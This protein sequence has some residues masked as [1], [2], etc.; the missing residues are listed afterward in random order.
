MCTA[1]LLLIS[2]KIRLII[3]NNILNLIDDVLIL[4]YEICWLP[5]QLPQ[6]WRD[7]EMELRILSL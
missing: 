3:N 4:V 6:L 5:T 7:L 2:I 1:W